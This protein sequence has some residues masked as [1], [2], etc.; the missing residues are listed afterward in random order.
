MSQCLY[1]PLQ[2]ATFI[3]LGVLLVM[4]LVATHIGAIARHHHNAKWKRIH[5]CVD[6]RERL[7]FFFGKLVDG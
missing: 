6:S 2:S 7:K 5:G 1:R 4:T 3:L